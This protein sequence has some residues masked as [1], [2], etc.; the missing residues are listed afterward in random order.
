MSG[1]ILPATIGIIFLSGGVI[2]WA[3]QRYQC[4]QPTVEQGVARY[5]GMFFSFGIAVA[6]FALAF[7]VL[8]IAR[9]NA[10]SEWSIIVLAVFGLL[11]VSYY[12][13]RTWLVKRWEWDAEGVTFIS[14]KRI[15][16][17]PWA[18]ITSGKWLI[19]GWRVTGPSGSVPCWYN[20][21]GY[22]VLSDALIKNR[23]DMAHITSLRA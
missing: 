21:V 15:T 20:V 10:R 2:D 4:V 11:G 6:L 18:D 16:R 19:G 9:P 3:S 17:L 22:Y 1:F 23:P 13:I 8:P 7:A 12:L 14:G 5:P